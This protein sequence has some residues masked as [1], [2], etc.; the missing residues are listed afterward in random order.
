MC[1]ETLLGELVAAVSIE[2][3][4]APLD[5]FFSSSR[6]VAAMPSDIRPADTRA[7]RFALTSVGSIILTKVEPAQSPKG[8]GFRRRNPRPRCARAALTGGFALAT[9]HGAE[10]GT[11]AEDR[12]PCQQNSQTTFAVLSESTTGGTGV[13]GVESADATT[14]TRLDNRLKV[15]P[16]SSTSTCKS[17]R[18]LAW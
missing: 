17:A 7:H 8:L 2:D 6:L 3:R 10:P 15:R 18:S 4:R 5:P 13:A 12:Q 1:S 9:S 11:D 16:D 14:V